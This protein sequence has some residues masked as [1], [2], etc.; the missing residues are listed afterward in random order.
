MGAL[1]PPLLSGRVSL[2]T[3]GIKIVTLISS[4]N[5]GFPQLCFLVKIYPSLNISFSSLF[6]YSNQL[7]SFAKYLPSFLLCSPP[8]FLF[9]PPF[10]SS[11]QKIKVPLAK[12]SIPCG[13]LCALVNA[14]LFQGSSSGASKAKGWKLG[15]QVMMLFLLG[16]FKV[17]RF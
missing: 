15:R 3:S 1:T 4:L 16:D 14:H 10:T 12:L 13:L 7:F 9:L 8:P 2:I 11:K 17:S 5:S 6:S